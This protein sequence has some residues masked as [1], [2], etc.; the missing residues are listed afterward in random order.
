MYRVVVR[1]HSDLVKPVDNLSYFT[2]LIG[3]I[4]LFHMA[5]QDLITD[6]LCAFSRFRA[7]MHLTRKRNLEQVNAFLAAVGVV[8]PRQ[9]N[10][11]VIQRYPG[12]V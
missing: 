1:I 5:D 7:K 8:L 6:C 9:N 4:G 12:Q 11:S 3:S 2:E 10:I